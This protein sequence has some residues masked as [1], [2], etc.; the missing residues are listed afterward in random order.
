MTKTVSRLAMGA[1]L[2]LVVAAAVRAFRPK[3]LEVDVA[4]ATRGRLRT[5]ID[6]EGRTRIRNRYV[7]GAAVNGRL[8]RIA[9]RE[10]DSVRA[11]APVAELAPAPLDVRS[12]EEARAHLTA[13]QDLERTAGAAVE[14]ARAALVQASR[15]RERTESLARSGVIAPEERERAQLAETSRKEELTAADFRAQ[16]AAHDVEVAQVAF[17]TPDARTGRMV[18]RIVVRAPAS[19]VV[20]RVLEQSERVVPAGTPLLELGNRRDLEVTTDLLSED[21][22]KSLWGTRSSSEAPARISSFEPW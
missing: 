21:A 17:R 19:G 5:T 1:A 6:D 12:L 11:G 18:Q 3:P 8:A 9:L 10:G 2:L 14:Q 20:L 4:Q 22:V 16:A 15:S 7:V 13:A